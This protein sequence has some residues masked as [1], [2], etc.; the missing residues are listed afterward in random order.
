M[1]HSATAT[2]QSPAYPKSDPEASPDCQGTISRT[3]EECAPRLP[4]KGPRLHKLRAP[5]SRKVF[6]SLGLRVCDPVPARSQVQV[7]AQISLPGCQLAQGLEWAV[8]A[9]TNLTMSHSLAN[10]IE[11]HRAR[12]VGLNRARQIQA[13]GML[14][15]LASEQFPLQVLP[16]IK[17][18]SS[19]AASSIP[20]GTHAFRGVRHPTCTPS[21]RNRNSC[22]GPT[23]SA[24]TC[25]GRLLGST[26]CPPYW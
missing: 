26:E 19:L 11:R 24:G 2:K 23:L 1:S 8:S 17:A 20:D 3:V 7:L 10:R 25:S 15:F 22:C 9:F 18:S 6:C 16:E 4:R 5:A 13:V 12:Q 21:E 14:A